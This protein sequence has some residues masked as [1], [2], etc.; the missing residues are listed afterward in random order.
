MEDNNNNYGDL[1]SHELVD[2]LHQRDQQVTNLTVSIDTLRR[3]N[4]KNVDRIRAVVNKFRSAIIEGVDVTIDDWDALREWFEDF[5]D[6]ADLDA[7]VRE[8]IFEFN[9]STSKRFS[10]RVTDPSLDESDIEDMLG[11]AIET[12]QHISFLPSDLDGIE[13][14]DDEDYSTEFDV[15]DVT[16][17]SND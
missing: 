4:H 16:L 9:V 2:L 11:E 12:Y 5:E 8:F 3:E 14:I 6:I 1:A 13:D 7:P 10:L 17:T 15:D